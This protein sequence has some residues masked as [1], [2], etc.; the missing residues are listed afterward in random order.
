MGLKILDHIPKS[1]RVWQAT[2]NHQKAYFSPNRVCLFLS[3]AWNKFTIK[4]HCP[5]ESIEMVQSEPEL[6][7]KLVLV[8]RLQFIIR[9]KRIKS[10]KR[11]QVACSE[12][13]Y[14]LKQKVLWVLSDRLYA[15]H[16]FFHPSLPK[17]ETKAASS[18]RF[19][20]VKALK[21]KILIVRRWLS[22]FHRVVGIAWP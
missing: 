2:K 18:N 21:R 4:L 7:E 10:F 17:G 13:K 11:T 12:S 20:H 22:F 9:P 16:R 1:D 6:E 15:N 8:P 19:N 3:T 14:H 5:E